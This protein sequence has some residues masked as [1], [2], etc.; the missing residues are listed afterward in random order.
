VRC[1][2]GCPSGDTDQFPN[3]AEETT[4]AMIDIVRAGGFTTGGFNFDAKVRRQSIDAA[5]LFHGN[6]GWIDTI[7]RAP[8]RAEGII[9]CSAGGEAEWVRFISNQPESGA[10]HLRSLFRMG[11]GNPRKRPP[12]PQLFSFQ[13]ERSTR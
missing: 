1:A 13:P 10:R 9:S 7:A 8:L 5:D 6:I 2:R 4:L 3:S 11:R 12:P